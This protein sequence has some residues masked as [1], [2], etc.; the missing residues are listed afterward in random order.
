VGRRAEDAV[1]DYLVVR[2]FEILAR[3]LH[4]G[5]DEIDILAR[6]GALVAIVE[7]RTRGPGS[8]ERALE[9]ISW[10]KRRYLL[11]AAAGVW[12]E[13]LRRMPEIER[14]RI[15]VAAV[16]FEGTKTTVEY[17]EGAVSR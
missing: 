5:H 9:S 16:T 10:K 4:V 8:F 15:D 13:R 12:R 1:A 14:V 7:V 2:G 17:I 3:N 11:R 6:D